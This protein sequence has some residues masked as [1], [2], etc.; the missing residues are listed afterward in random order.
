[1]VTRMRARRLLL[2]TLST[3]ATPTPTHEALSAVPAFMTQ[4]R[5]PLPLLAYAVPMGHYIPLAP[6][7]DEP[8]AHV[9]I[10]DEPDLPGACGSATTR[11]KG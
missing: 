5:L 3:A 9:G 7:L 1:M 10:G 11:S 4:S 2:R 8:L 6:V